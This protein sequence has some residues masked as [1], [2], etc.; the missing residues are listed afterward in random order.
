MVEQQQP[1]QQEEVLSSSSSNLQ[2]EATTTFNNQN[3]MKADY[4]PKILESLQFV[5][6]FT[7]ELPS[8]PTKLNYVRQVP[9]ACYSYCKP[10]LLMKPIHE[11][12]TDSTSFLTYFLNLQE[13]KRKL[14]DASSD[15][16]SEEDNNKNNARVT[17]FEL[18]IA[19]NEV[20]KDCLQQSL[21]PKSNNL[22]ETLLSHNNTYITKDDLQYFFLQKL[23]NDN[24]E[25]ITMNEEMIKN[26][27]EKIQ[28]FTNYLCGYET[29]EN[30]IKKTK[31][32]AHCYAGHQFGYFAGQLGD[33]RA[34]N[35]GQIKLNH[36]SSF[37]L[38]NNDD[39]NRDSNTNM[40]SRLSQQEKYN[41]IKEEDNLFEQVFE[42]Q[43]KGAGRTPY[44][45]NG[46]GRAVLRSSIREFLCSE[47]MFHLG[48]PTSRA[49][50]L[51]VSK[52]KVIERD[53]FYNRNIKYEFGAIVLR[54]ASSFIRFGSFEVFLY[55]FTSSLM[56]SEERREELKIIDLLVDHVIRHYFPHLLQN[57][58]NDKM[59]SDSKNDK[60]EFSNTK[61]IVKSNLSLTVKLEWAK[62]VIRRTAKLMSDWQCYGFVHGVMNTDNMSILGITIDYGPF[63][64][65]D[66]FNENFVPN[67][68]D[69]EGRYR[70]ANQ[71]EI[72]YWNCNKLIKTLS[73]LFPS[74][75]M[76]DE[77]REQ[78][79][80]HYNYF[81]L[82]TM[83]QKLGLMP[84]KEL[85][86]RKKNLNRLE[87]YI[88]KEVKDENMF[89]GDSERLRK[90]DLELIKDLMN[91][92]QESHADFTLFFRLLS[93]VGFYY[94]K[95]EENNIV[96]EEFVNLMLQKTLPQ[97]VTTCQRSVCSSDTVEGTTVDQEKKNG[98]M[99]WLN[100]YIKRLN[101]EE[102]KMEMTREERKERMNEINPRYVLRNSLVHDIIK[103]ATEGNYESFYEYF[104]VL[105]DPFSD[106]SSERQ[107]KYG[108]RVP[109]SKL[110]IKLSCSS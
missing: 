25:N 81:Y 101:S 88:V 59:I 83:R 84:N 45:R 100:K 92:L 29:L 42:L 77:I 39:N 22:N 105:T 106:Q 15:D 71:P 102:I 24:N 109:E 64:F 13:R 96:D 11:N 54:I 86:I 12:V 34:I 31:Y 40:E 53:E 95:K 72:G 82:F 74:E 61:K 51:V 107:E 36:H 44:S 46:D 27:Q 78:Y 66:Y 80:K 85:M 75:K 55:R 6:Y 47:F 5:N 90:L 48:I 57:S 56:E 99:N 67:F 16:S 38:D 68:S 93:D 32:Y 37:I 94:T 108:R 20:A 73:H 2:K 30:T 23:Q 110:N 41:H 1:L 103:E 14:R 52:D 21:L 87:D 89:E 60:D 18:I 69:S 58:G 104:E 33:G 7:K 76:D 49:L 70:Y 98:L 43:M 19:S 63:G 10:S 26:N 8:D 65:V 35:I 17:P 9:H 79:W 4:L 62:E 97:I 28:L 3:Y 50:S 91:W